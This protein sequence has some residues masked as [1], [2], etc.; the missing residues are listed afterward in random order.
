MPVQPR[1]AQ[2]LQCVVCGSH[3]ARTLSSTALASGAVVII[4][5][6]HALAHGRLDRPARSVSEL[7]TMLGERRAP[8]DRRD[9]ETDELARQLA[10]AF[11]PER[12]IA[13]RRREDAYSGA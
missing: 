13:G 5:G 12:R 7:R 6:S 9:C 1:P 4:C 8:N 3:D 2:P 10:R 11:N